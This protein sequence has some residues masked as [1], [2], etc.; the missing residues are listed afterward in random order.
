MPELLEPHTQG[1]LELFLEIPMD[2]YELLG[3]NKTADGDE[4]KRAYRTL[5]LKFHPDKNPGD[6]EA[7]EKFKQINEAY[8]ALSDPEKRAEYDQYG[9]VG[10]P[11]GGG[12]NPNGGMGDIFDLFN[13]VFGGDV[14]GQQGGRARG[15]NSAAR[16]S[17]SNKHV[18]GPTLKSKWTGSRA[19]LTAK[20]NAANPA[21]KACKPAKPAAGPDRSDKCNARSW[22]IS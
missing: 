13:S 5:A 8:G 16:G 3:V 14:F 17:R 20:A 7:E 22:A 4:I 1:K 15:R 19:A 21:A 2:Y 18:T 9:K 12:F 10:G 6:K 11:A